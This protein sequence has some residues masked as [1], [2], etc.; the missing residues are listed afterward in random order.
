[1]G[2]W[3]GCVIASGRSSSDRA[4]VLVDGLRP[5]VR[6][7]SC[8]LVARRSRPSA[9]GRR[10]QPRNAIG[11]LLL[12]WSAFRFVDRRP[13]SRRRRDRAARPRG[14]ASGSRLAERRLDPASSALSASCCC[15]R[16]ASCPS[17]R[18][19]PGRLARGR[20]VGLVVLIAAVACT[21]RATLEALGHIDNPLGLRRRGQRA[22]G[23]RSC[24]LTVAAPASIA[25]GGAGRPLPRRAASSGMQLK[26]FAVAG[27]LCRRRV[28]V[29]VSPAL[30]GALLGDRVDTR[31][32]WS[33]LIARRL[34][35]RGRRSRSCAT[36]ST[37]S[38]S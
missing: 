8:S 12:R 4:A 7:R 14:S 22:R 19:R 20:R 29:V 2:A 26:W 35:G 10:R 31:S 5:A 36:G 28:L 9:R 27:A 11:W 37:T 17:P 23:A 15:S 21:S 24:R 38:T 1:M 16:T 30:L 32:W 3:P 6:P 34:P 18:W 13:A 25:R 33:S